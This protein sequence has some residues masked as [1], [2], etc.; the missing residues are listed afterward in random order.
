VID[1][2]HSCATA[3]SK[4]QIRHNVAKIALDFMA[5]SPLLVNSEAFLTG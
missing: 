1:L 2:L 3:K 4:A 5:V